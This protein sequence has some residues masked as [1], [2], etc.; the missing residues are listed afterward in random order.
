[1]PVSSSISRRVTTDGTPAFRTILIWFLFTTF[2]DPGGMG[3]SFLPAA[4]LVILPCCPQP[5]EGTEKAPPDKCALHD[6][7]SYFFS[8]NVPRCKSLNA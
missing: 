2:V 8:M 1:M 3:L 5:S 4:S 7:D 6:A